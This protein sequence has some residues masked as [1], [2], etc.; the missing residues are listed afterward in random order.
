MCRAEV[1]GKIVRA[2]E[3]GLREHCPHMSEAQ[4]SRTAREFGDALIARFREIERH[5]DEAT[6]E[7]H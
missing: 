1:V 7:L 3:A 6:G 5:E 4:I 2:I